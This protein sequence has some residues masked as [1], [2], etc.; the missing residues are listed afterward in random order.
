MLSILFRYFERTLYVMIGIKNESK[1]LSLAILFLFSYI[2]LSVIKIKEFY[3]NKLK[4]IRILATVINGLFLKPSTY[5]IIESKINLNSFIT[6]QHFMRRKD[7]L[8]SAVKVFIFCPIYYPP[9]GFSKIW[10][11]KR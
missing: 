3:K 5:L 6:S 11:F 4:G 9:K 8:F 10:I 1:L 7:F 2:R